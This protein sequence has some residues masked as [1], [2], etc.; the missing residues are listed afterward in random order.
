M[1]REKNYT[2]KEKSDII[3]GIRT[4]IEAVQASR[5]INKILI[6]KGMNKDLFMELKNELADKD[7]QLQFV[8]VEKLNAQILQSCK[9]ETYFHT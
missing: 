7:Y 1:E 3:F 6:Q 2:R 8:P 5:E 9:S 4:V